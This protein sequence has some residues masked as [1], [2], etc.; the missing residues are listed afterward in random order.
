MMQASSTGKMGLIAQLY[1]MDVISN[2][3]ANTNT[4]GFKARSV[5]FQ[6][7]LYNTM[8]RPAGDQNVNLQRGTG[9]QVASTPLSLTPGIAENTGGLLDFMID[10][11]GFFAVQGLDGSVEYTR[12]GSFAVSVEDDGN[13]LVNTQGLYVLD[14]EGRRIM[15]PDDE[16]TST[17][18][19]DSDGGLHMGDD[20]DELS[21]R[22]AVMGIFNFNNP[23]GLE[24]SGSSNFKA[25]GASGEAILVTDGNMRVR[26]GFV[27]ASN[28]EVSMEMTQLIRTQR[29]F[30]FASRCITTADEMEA[31]A[32]N[33]PNT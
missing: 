3:I 24:N 29:A 14:T 19:I 27:E 30:S 10:G 1:R 26:Q 23:Y 13:Y 6:D 21:T 22:F 18:S 25:N 9:V 32:N 12:N 5:T 4:Q 2:N 33:M 11:D 8:Y 17:I 15:F 20:T 31:I 16:M 28:T 7:M